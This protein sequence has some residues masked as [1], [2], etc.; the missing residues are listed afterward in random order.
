MVGCLAVGGEQ[1]PG[2]VVGEVSAGYVGE[3]FAGAGVVAEFDLEG[4]WCHCFPYA[5]VEV[6]VSTWGLFVLW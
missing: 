5:V 3:H 2:V 4:W 6:V 1:E